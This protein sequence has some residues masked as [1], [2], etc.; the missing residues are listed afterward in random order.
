[1]KAIVA[2][3]YGGPEVLQLKEV[4][5]PQPK[6]NE[7]LIKVHATTV[8]MGD[9][10]MRSFTVPPVFWLPARL[11]L[12]ITKPKQPIYGMELAGRVESIGK[13]VTR[14]KIGDQ[15][16]AS[17]L[18][19]NFGAYAEYKCLPEK[20]MMAIKP[21]NISFEEAAALPIGATTALRLLRKGK[22]QRGQ[23]VMIYGASG[24]VG[25][26]AIQLAKHLGA[27]VTG[28]C[29]TANLEMVKS[30]GADHVIDYT[31][32]TL[33]AT[34]ERY[35][36]IFDT[37][38]K[39]AKSKAS[40]ILMPNGAYITMAQLDSK[41]SMD[42]LIFIKELVEAGKLK[43]VIDRCYPLEDMVEAHRYVDS[44]HKKGNVV[45]TVGNTK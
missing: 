45:I 33:S 9:F 27:E 37:V 29:S 35:D 5:K 25:T 34:K 32:E 28:V 14:F 10:R 8:T 12:G 24:S 22:I 40:Q 31:K 3:Q 11:T 26:Y 13:N 18:T 39:F 16:F 42:N 21:A 44:G 23:K 20:A 17:T 43:V 19:E 4:G 41:E 36:V 7:V 15:V 30:L 38:G 6:D 1:M 2:N